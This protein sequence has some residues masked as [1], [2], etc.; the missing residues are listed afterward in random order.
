MPKRLHVCLL[1]LLASGI[2]NAQNTYAPAAENLTNRE[3]FQDAKFGLFIHWG[4]YSVLGQ[5]EWVMQTRALDRGT[6]ERL[7]SFFNPLAFDAKEWVSLAKAAGMK[8]IT[9][10]SRHHDG[11][12]MFDTRHSD[13]DV[14][15]RTPFKKDILRILA[16]E[17]QRQ[18]IK[19]F[20]YYSH[21]DWWHQDYYPRGSTGLASGRP[22]NGTW[23]AYLD[24]VNAQLT[25]LLTNYGPIAGIWFDG[26]W[27]KKGADW[28]LEKTYALIHSLQPG[29]LVGNNH[30]G[31]PKEG[32]D[33]QMFE[34]DLPGQN[35][36]GFGAEA[37]V[38]EL[39]LETCETMNN[40]WGFNLF[41]KNLKSAKELIQYLVRAA[42]HNGNFL[43]NVGPMPDGRIQPEF[44]ATLKEIGTWVT[45]YGESIYGTRGGPVPPRSW[46]V[47]TQKGKRIFIHDLAGETHLLIPGFGRT[48]SRVYLFDNDA[49]VRFTQGELGISIEIPKPMINETDTIVVVEVL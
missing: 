30:H 45:Q 25:E 21:L 31:A 2:S 38:G 22:D 35:L 13:W 47:T 27:D 10:T 20:L 12:S 19:L 26:I 42:G 15:D 24:F 33:F 11:F 8:Y 34:K 3:W 40:S 48:V 49:P 46:G 18:G 29:C 14:V 43:L 32:E 44:V 7:A 23:S 39:P 17:C 4:I 1:I 5:G 36:S 28:E 37:T 6:Y 41:D 16:D 9:I